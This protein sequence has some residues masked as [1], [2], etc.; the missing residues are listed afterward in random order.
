MTDIPSISIKGKPTEIVVI[1]P[2]S[3]PSDDFVISF[4][5]N[6]DF[7]RTYYVQGAYR[8]GDIGIHFVMSN[9][10]A[11][12]SNTGE[13]VFGT[14]AQGVN[15]VSYIL[16]L[17][18][19][20]SVWVPYQNIIFVKYDGQNWTKVDQLSRGDLADYKVRF[21]RDTPARSL[22]DTP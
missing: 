20:N 2:L 18:F 19:G 21:E 11:V 17:G 6:I 10:M 5:R 3:V 13:L 1:L 12:G 4:A 22:Y 8:R 15:M 16:P 9:S 7:V 14:N